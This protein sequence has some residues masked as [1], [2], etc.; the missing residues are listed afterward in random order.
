MSFRIGD[1]AQAREAILAN[2]REQA[3][4][5]ER[6]QADAASVGG[7]P[8]QASGATGSASEASGTKFTEQLADGLQAV[9][10]EIT[11]ADALPE[12]LLNGQI[13][14]FHEVAVQVKRADLSFKF[15][16]EVRNKL[17]DAYREVMRMPV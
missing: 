13:N 3:R 10:D 11:K 6:V 4:A 17:L 2:L 8:A 9:Q 14:D 5:R 15:A 7:A 1:G 12:Q 16:L